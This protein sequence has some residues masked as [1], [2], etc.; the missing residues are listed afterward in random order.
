MAIERAE[1]YTAIGSEDFERS[2]AFYS[3]LFGREPDERLGD[4]YGAFRMPGLHLG[5]F[6]P[7]RGGG[8]D[9]RNPTDRRG[10]LS[11]VLAVP[12]VERAAAEVGRLGGSA[13]P[14]FET[15]HGREAYAYDPD[16]NRLILVER[17]GPTDP[18]A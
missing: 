8:G 13:S 3:G 12:S 2:I 16:G 6:R 17:G 5:I 7:R 1:A 14:A 10:G 9:F 4:V 11:L 15:S 18:P